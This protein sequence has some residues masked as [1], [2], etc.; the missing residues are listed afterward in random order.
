MRGIAKV[1]D[2]ID[3]RYANFWDGYIENTSEA[4]EKEIKTCPVARFWSNTPEL[5]EVYLYELFKAM[6]EELNSKFKFLG[7]SKLLPKD[8]KFCRYRIEIEDN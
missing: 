5:C 7:F 6:G 2:T 4:F 3:D 8:D 1:S